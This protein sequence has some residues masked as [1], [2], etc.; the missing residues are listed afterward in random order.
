MLKNY[1]RN[2][3]LMFFPMFKNRDFTVHFLFLL[4]R[5]RERDTHTHTQTERQVRQ[6][7]TQTNPRKNTKKQRQ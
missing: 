4:A 6:T 3:K 2:S 5:E 1:E 7:K